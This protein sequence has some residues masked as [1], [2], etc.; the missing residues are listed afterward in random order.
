MSEIQKF[1]SKNIKTD[2]LRV[3]DDPEVDGLV[4]IFKKK[5][6]IG[7]MIHEMVSGVGTQQETVIRTFLN[8]VKALLH[9]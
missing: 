2:M 6:Q 4:L 3:L 7:C 9:F 8:L 1:D 5:N